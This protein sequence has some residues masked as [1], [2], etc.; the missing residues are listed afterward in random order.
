MEETLPAKLPIIPEG[1][2]R[3]GFTSAQVLAATLLKLRPPKA[4]S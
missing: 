4:L 1:A 3:G 2:D